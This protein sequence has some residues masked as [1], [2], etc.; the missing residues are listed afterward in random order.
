MRVI[1]TEVGTRPYLM[2]KAR[3][4]APQG[5]RVLADT[6]ERFTFADSAI[7]VLDWSNVL[8]LQPEQAAKPIVA[9]LTEKF[10]DG[11][12]LNVSLNVDVEETFGND[13]FMA[14]DIIEVIK[15]MEQKTL[16]VIGGTQ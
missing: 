9:I 6:F 8:G 14:N 5:I 7:I 12:W 13:D 2:T 16:G 1:A 11:R 10:H 3:R 15:I 4:F